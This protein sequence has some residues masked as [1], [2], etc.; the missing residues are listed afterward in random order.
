[1]KK[2]IKKY[3]KNHL[4]KFIYNIIIFLY[5]FFIV[6]PRFVFKKFGFWDKTRFDLEDLFNI[7]FKHKVKVGQFVFCP[8]GAFILHECFNTE[9]YKPLLSCKKVLSLG[10]FI[11]DS[12]IYLSQRCEKIYT[13][14]P[15]KQ[16]F[17][18]LKKNLSLNNLDKKIIPYNYAVVVS[19]V[20]NIGIKNSSSFD[21]DASIT[22]FNDINAKNSEVVKCIHIKDVLK[23]ENF[24][25]FKCDIEGAEWDIIEYFIKYKG[26]WNFDKA[27]F[28][29]HFGYKTFES[30]L[31]ILNEFFEFL[32]NKN[33]SYCFFRD[34]PKFC[35]SLSSFKIKPDK[36]NQRRVIMMYIR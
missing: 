13:F 29:L 2:R 1:M 27:I 8:E 24:D 30:E 19:G 18:I 9:F 31:K 11:G 34:S 10:G 16:K 36:E 20:K 23:L 6:N 3:L 25:G 28:E 14:E 17:K 21:G 12:A 26:M 15:G 7:R 35:K 33:L 4:N 32:E 5:A 22:D